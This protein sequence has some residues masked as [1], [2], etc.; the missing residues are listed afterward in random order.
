MIGNANQTKVLIIGLEGASLDAIQ[1]ITRKNQLPFLQKVIDTASFGNLKSTLPLN[2]AAS[3]ASF[4]T[5]KN[6]GKHS[7]YD[8]VKPNGSLLQPKIIDNDYIQSDLMW[9]I[10]DRHSLKSIFFNIPIVTKPEK[11]NGIMVSGFAT[12]KDQPFAYPLSIHQELLEQEFKFN[13]E[14]Y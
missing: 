3:W 1:K 5:G 9:H 11:V 8:F 12:L 2:G 6:P 13:T 10:S 7:I 4:F 14:P